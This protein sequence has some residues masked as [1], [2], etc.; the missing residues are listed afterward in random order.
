MFQRARAMS[1]IGDDRETGTR[2]PHDRYAPDGGD[3]SGGPKKR[4]KT[5][6]VSLPLWLASPDANADL[7]SLPW[8]TTCPEARIE[9]RNSV[10]IGYVYP[11]TS[12]STAV[13]SSLLSHLSRIVHPAIPVSQL[14]PQFNNSAPSRRGSTHDMYAFRVMQLKTG[15]TGMGGPSD[16]GIAQGVEDD[17]EK[18]GGDRVMRAVRDLGASDVLV[19]VSRWYG[20]ELLG[21][22]RFEHIEKTAKMALQKHMNNEVCLGS[23]AI[24]R[25]RTKLQTLDKEIANARGRNYAENPYSDLTIERGRRLLIARTKSLESVARE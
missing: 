22:V 16:F 2:G 4:Q 15:R 11:L 1:N 17:G 13:I 7:N 20:G 21:P 5:N 9:D 25:M 10:F 24:D 6:A 14:P 8:P 18:W 19:V 3:E 12:A 23:Q